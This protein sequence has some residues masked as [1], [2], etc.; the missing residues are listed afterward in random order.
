L[1]SPDLA[2]Q[3]ELFQDRADILQVVAKRLAPLPEAVI[4]KT[5]PVLALLGV[6]G[7]AFGL[8]PMLITTESTC[9]LGQK[10]CGGNGNSR[11]AGPC[12]AS[13]TAVGPYSYCPVGPAAVLRL[14]F[15]P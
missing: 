3:P 1:F 15:A 6:S 12:Q 8:R 7:S 10:D 2:W 4:Q 11:C 14:P 5:Q 9:G 13:R